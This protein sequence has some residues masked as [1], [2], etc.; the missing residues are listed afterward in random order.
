MGPSSF[1]TPGSCPGHSTLQISSDPCV[2][3]HWV[4][5]FC[6]IPGTVFDPATP[7]GVCSWPWPLPIRREV[8]SALAGCPGAT[9]VPASGWGSGMGAACSFCPSKPNA[10]SSVSQHHG[11]MEPQTPT[12]PRHSF[13]LYSGQDFS[14]FLNSHGLWGT[15][16]QPVTYLDQIKK[17]DIIAVFKP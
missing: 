3:A 14:W 1:P 9:G 4:L 10:R 2:W 11:P 6:L 17:K 5:F 13:P 8:L 12:V 7:H 15:Q 16:S